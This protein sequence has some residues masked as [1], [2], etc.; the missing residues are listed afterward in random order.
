[1]RISRG[2]SG[3]IEWLSQ[4]ADVEMNTSRVVTLS[5]DVRPHKEKV[6]M[7]TKI[8]IHLSLSGISVRGPLTVETNSEVTSCNAKRRVSVQQ[9]VLAK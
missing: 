6:I 1:M 7:A 4:V 5:K 8:R 3:T 9:Q 2:N